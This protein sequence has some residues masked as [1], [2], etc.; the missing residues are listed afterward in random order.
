MAASGGIF[1]PIALGILRKAVKDASKVLRKKVSHVAQTVTA[2]SSPAVQAAPVRSSVG[3]AR[4]QPVHPA[5]VL[6]QQRRLFSRWSAAQQDVGSAARRFLSSLSEA[7]QAAKGPRFD[8]SKFPVS[9]TS[10]AVSQLPGRAPF[11]HT[12]RPNLTGGALPRSAGGYGITGTGARYFSHAPAAPAQVVQNVSQAMRAFFLSGQRARFDGVDANGRKRWR[13]VSTLEDETLRT[14]SSVP[15]C[16]PGSFI[17]FRLS[18]TIT[19]MSPLAAAFPF[20]A[21]AAEEKMQKKG[22]AGL[23]DGGDFVPTTYAYAAKVQQKHIAAQASPTSLNTVGFLE[24]LS[25]DFARALKDLAATLGDI[26]RLSELGDLTVEMVSDSKSPTLRVRFPGVDAETVEALCNDVGVTRG[27]VGQDN[28]FDASVGVP[29]ALQFP[30]APDSRNENTRTITS[31]S[32]SLRSLE[33]HELAED[34]DYLS[35]AEEAFMLDE[36][37]ENPWVSEPEAYGSLSK[38]SFTSGDHCSEDFEGVSGIYRFIEECDR[39][40]GQFRA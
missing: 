31:P 24:E 16:V 40:R 35:E 23:F 7:A 32:G 38:H 2:S 20:A 25:L 14:M 29:I 22:A 8:R 3:G 37:S 5:A 34:F 11:A 6:R 30:F 21:A 26:K 4:G 10:R 39:A 9:Q 15:R 28:G 17:D 19:A 33:G 18:P 12:L 13:T 36:F 27:L 1:A